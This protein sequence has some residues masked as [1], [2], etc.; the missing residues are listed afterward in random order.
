[1]TQQP[2]IVQLALLIRRGQ[3]KLDNVPLDIRAAVNGVM[4][5]LTD[6][7]ESIL[8]R[9]QETPRKRHLGRSRVFERASS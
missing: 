6:A 1:M 2:D 7:Q 5:R 3:L 8:A 4:H 9:A